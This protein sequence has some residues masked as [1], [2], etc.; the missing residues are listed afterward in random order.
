MRSSG[1]NTWLLINEGAETE[2]RHGG[3]AGGGGGG[4]RGRGGGGGG[5]GERYSQVLFATK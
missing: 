2:C 5:R 4:G 1:K 3:G